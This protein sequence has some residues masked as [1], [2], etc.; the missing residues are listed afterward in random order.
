MSSSMERFGAHLIDASC[1]RQSVVALSSGEAEFYALTRSAAIG[2]MTKQIWDVI[3]FLGLPLVVKTDSTA[4]KGIAGRKGVGRVK[5]LDLRDL[6]VQDLVARGDLRVEK[7]P[8]DN[9]LG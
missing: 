3:G 7:E 9:E 8:T 1:A 2:R 6:W 5:H 4:A